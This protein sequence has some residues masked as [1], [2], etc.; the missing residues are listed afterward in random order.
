MITAAMTPPR[1]FRTLLTTVAAMLVIAPAVLAANPVIT[2]CLTHPAGLT[3]HYTVAQL[4]YAL[5]HMPQET[6]EYTNCPDVINRAVLAAAHP[7]R[8]AQP[9]EG[10]SGSF[11]PTPVLVILVVLML[12]AGG[13]ALVAVRRRRS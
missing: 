9:V 6:Q 1:A 13:F 3:G 10:S 12:I 4:Q 7:L 2:D 8:P 11:L 5:H